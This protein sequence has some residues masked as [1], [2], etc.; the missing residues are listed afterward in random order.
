MDFEQR[1][2]KAIERGQRASTAREQADVEKALSE[3]EFK[4]LHTQFRL[5]ISEHIES[6]LAKL[7]HHFPGFQF[8]RVLNE[9]GWGAKVSR[10]DLTP[11]ADR[12]RTNAYSR[13]EMVVRPYSAYHVLELTAKGTVRNKEIYNRTHYQRLEQVDPESFLELVDLWV[14]EYAEL[15]AAKS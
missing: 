1:L 11:G 9:R 7:P 10:D 3:E 4:R 15:Y 6:C 5:T 13:L 2:E 8:E 12:R 14:L